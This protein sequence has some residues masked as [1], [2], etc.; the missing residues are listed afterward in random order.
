MTDKFKQPSGVRDTLPAECAAKR[1]I[2]QKL[3]SKFGQYGYL[4]I[5]TPA[6]EYGGLYSEGDRFD[7][8]RLFKFSDCDGALLVLRPDMTMPISRVVATK[9]APGRY[10]LCYLG[11]TYRLTR[12]SNGLREFTQA[13]VEYM[14]AS[15]TAC[16]AEAVALA[17]ESLLACGLEDFIID[18][19]HVGFFGGILKQLG[20]DEAKRR[21]LAALVERKDVIGESLFAA[22]EGL[23]SES[24]SLLAGLPMLFGDGSVLERARDLCLNDEMKKSLDELD[25]LNAA[26]VKA[27]Y[28]DRISYDLSLVGEMSYYSG[29]VFKGLCEGAGSSVL[30]GGRYDRL[31][32]AFGR[33]VPSVGFAI[34]V[35]R[36]VDVLPANEPTQSVDEVI[37]CDGTPDGIAAALAYASAATSKG[38]NMKLKRNMDKTVVFALAKGR[39]AEKSADILCRCGIDCANILEPT[40]KLVLTDAS[41]AYEF[42][43]V[44]PSDVPVYVERGVA[45]IGVVG[46]DTLLESGADVYEL[47]DLRFAAC[48]LA[49]AGYP[50][51]DVKEARNGLK[52]ATKYGNF[53]RSYFESRGLNADI[54]PLHGSIELGPIVGLSDIILDIVESGKT[55][56]E[57]GLVVLE[58]I[59]DCSA[60]L[61]V[62]KVSL[63]TKSKAL[64]PLVASIKQAVAEKI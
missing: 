31:C 23:T 47:V 64:I 30:S 37:G 9:F 5:D 17:I 12:R 50:G 43:F 11:S 13:G 36:L 63:K 52:V 62:N 42:I 56:K 8:D 21:E 4:Q 34:A 24:M 28:G 10:K 15:G 39:L 7:L 22:R 33:S 40:R 58:E 20:L 25:A 44:K 48:K 41:G 45:D 29:L 32:D 1:A 3:L 57:N 61:I 53:A 54:I 51:F 27:G 18:I 59:C 38:R 49:L 35:D 16:D 55:L 60:R 6:L 46:K 14:G 19:G 2:E 26:L